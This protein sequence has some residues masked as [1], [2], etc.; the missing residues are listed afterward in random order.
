[1]KT[2]ILFAVVCALLLTS[3]M[4]GAACV[5]GT[6]AS[7][8]SLGSTGCTIGDKTFSNF[9][10]VS[11]QGGSAVAPTNTGITVSPV[12]L[13]N[14]EIGLNFNS[15]WSAG[16]N[17]FVDTTIGFD[18]AVTGGGAFLIEDASVV[19]SASGFTG[20]G[21]ANVDEGLCGPTPCS[22][23]LTLT[24]VNTQGST[25]LSSHQVFTPTGSVHAVKD[26][27]VSGGTN[28]TASISAV[29]DTF[30]Q[31]AVPEPASIFLMGSVLVGVCGVIRRRRS[32]KA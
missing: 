9:S 22:T 25:V 26:I 21:S 5:T 19:Q 3:Q 6:L 11:S 29:Q 18:V 30:S 31:T 27:G 4:W 13:A 20:T 32:Q 24:T 7:Y 23:T 1:V 12:T 8:Q 16:S 28:G 15:L 17:S 14:G 2:K 10:F